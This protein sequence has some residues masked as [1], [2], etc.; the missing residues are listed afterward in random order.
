MDDRQFD[1]LT[2][3]IGSG[4]SRR[5]LLK[6]LLGGAGVIGLVEIMTGSGDAARRGFTG[7]KLPDTPTVIPL[8]PRPPTPTAPAQGGCPCPSGYLCVN[9]G[10]VRQ[11]GSLADCAGFSTVECVDVPELGMLCLSP[12]VEGSCSVLADCPYQ[13]VCLAGNCRPGLG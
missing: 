10:C 13:Y 3:A 4:G 2:R 6:G 7:P 12:L 5:T 9:D 1:R 11:C 8:T